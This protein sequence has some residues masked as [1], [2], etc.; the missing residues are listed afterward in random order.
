MICKDSESPIGYD[1]GDEII[2][3][4]DHNIIINSSSYSPYFKLI[5]CQTFPA[6][7]EVIPVYTVLSD[8][9]NDFSLAQGIII[10]SNSKTR[11]IL[12]ISVTKS[13]EGLINKWVIC[14]FECIEFLSRTV[15]K[16][17]NIMLGFGIIG[18]IVSNIRPLKILSSEA[19]S[20]IPLS[21]RT[22]F[23]SN[24]RFNFMCVYHCS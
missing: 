16:V 10:P 24:V 19:R 14:H 17:V 8:P 6:S 7:S 9:E 12:R 11:L 21:S 13:F 22:Y 4:S 3:Y 5:S 20:F 15:S 23:D 18:R 1:I 2:Y